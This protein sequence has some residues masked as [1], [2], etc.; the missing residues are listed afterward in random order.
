MRAVVRLQ[1]CLSEALD[2]HEGSGNREAEGMSG[3]ERSAR[4]V[5]D[6]DLDAVFIEIFENL[7]SN[8]LAFG[9]D[10]TEQRAKQYVRE[11]PDA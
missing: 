4:H 10:L 3:V 11:K 8:D 5:V 1:V 6:V 7:F 9:S 2:V